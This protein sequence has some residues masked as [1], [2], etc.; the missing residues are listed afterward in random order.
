MSDNFWPGRTPSIFWGLYPTQFFG[1]QYNVALHWGLPAFSELLRKLID[2]TWLRLWRN[3]TFAS[4][5][6]TNSRRTV[7]KAFSSWLASWLASPL[8][9]FLLHAKPDFRCS[10]N[11]TGCYGKPLTDRPPSK[12]NITI[13]LRSFVNFN[14]AYYSWMRSCWDCFQRLVWW[15]L[16]P[17]TLS[18]SLSS[19]ELMGREVTR[20]RR[21]KT[22]RCSRHFI[23][24][25]QNLQ[26]IDSTVLF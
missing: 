7:H 12:D 14:G 3:Y 9:F 21:I 15:M 16:H 22:F 20:F 17:A 5:S 18:S 23:S 25:S 24:W 11:F 8:R 13:P 10:H 19:P 1:L 2:R 4:S 26:V 6:W